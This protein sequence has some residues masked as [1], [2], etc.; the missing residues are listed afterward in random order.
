MNH[1]NMK[2]NTTILALLLAYCVTF[3]YPIYASSA[4]CQL[5][6][7]SSI[8]QAKMWYFHLLMRCT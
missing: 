1:R 2:E 3:A 4:M 7:R 8:V 6:Q 5:Q